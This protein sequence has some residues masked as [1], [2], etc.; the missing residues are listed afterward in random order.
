ML[1][2]FAKHRYISTQLLI[3]PTFTVLLTKGIPCTKC[4][5]ITWC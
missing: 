3:Y 1:T 5:C 4:Y 2:K